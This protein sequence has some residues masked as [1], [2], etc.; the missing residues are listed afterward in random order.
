MEGGVGSGTA[1]NGQ[2]KVQWHALA[3]NQRGRE[4]RWLVT[5]QGDAGE[6]KIT[7]GQKVKRI[8]PLYA[9]K[10]KPRNAWPACARR[11]F[12]SMGAQWPARPPCWLLA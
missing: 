8:S 6:K 5:R 10:E 2:G 7:W 11:S 3:R 9:V 12:Y 4:H 1:E